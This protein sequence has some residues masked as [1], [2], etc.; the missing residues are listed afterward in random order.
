MMTISSIAMH[1]KKSIL[2]TASDDMSWKIWTV[3]K[4]ELIMSGEGGH[5]DWISGIDFHPKGLHLATSS[6]DSTIKIWDFV[7]KGAIHTFKDHVQPVWNI[8]FHD[9]GDFLVSASMDHTCKI[10]DLAVGKA[11]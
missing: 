3:P 2:A 11:R 4:G 7:N 10:F 9:T 8:K 6:G 1:P 5:K